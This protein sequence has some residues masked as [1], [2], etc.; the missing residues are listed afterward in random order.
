M[1]NGNTPNGD[2]MMN[3]GTGLTV[4]VSREN[5]NEEHDFPLW[6]NES[7]RCFVFML[8]SGWTMAQPENLRGQFVESNREKDS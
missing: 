1:S 4:V 6:R 3:L 8:D 7:L 2:A 5:D